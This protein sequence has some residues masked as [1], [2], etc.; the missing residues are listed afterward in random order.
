MPKP[1][2]YKSMHEAADTTSLN[3]S[4]NYQGLDTNKSYKI[5]I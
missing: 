4:A 2:F 5:N 3:Y 1:Y